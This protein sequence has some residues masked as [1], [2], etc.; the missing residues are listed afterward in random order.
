[1]ELPI[2][3]IAPRCGGVGR[4]GLRNLQH[5]TSAQQSEYAHEL[6]DTYRAGVALDLS[7]ASL[8]QADLF[9]ELRLA[10][11]FRPAQGSKVRGKLVRCDQGIVHRHF[12]I[13][14]MQ[15]SPLKD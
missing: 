13:G 12:T 9:A 1:M 8:R 10:K 5:E 6:S 11:V 7:Y 4:F 3:G 15:G 2:P 14:A